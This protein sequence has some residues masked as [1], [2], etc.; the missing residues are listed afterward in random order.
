MFIIGILYE[1]L[2]IYNIL[3]YN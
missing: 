1:H 2:T 3:C